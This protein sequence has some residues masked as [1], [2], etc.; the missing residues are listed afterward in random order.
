MDDL[1]TLCPLHQV[2]S[3]TVFSSTLVVVPSTDMLEF[4]GSPGGK[5][6]LWIISLTLF[7]VEIHILSYSE[8]GR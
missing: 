7:Q 8:G 5:L 1:V 2:P 6:A 4:L 3:T